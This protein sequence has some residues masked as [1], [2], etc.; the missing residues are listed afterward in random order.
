MNNLLDI[1]PKKVLVS[2]LILGG[3]AFIILQN[4]PK[5]LCDIQK[6]VFTSNQLGFLF[7]DP[8]DKIKTKTTFK[9]NL[10]DC[11]KNNNPG[12]CYSLF[13]NIPRVIQS[14][15]SVESSCYSQIAE[16]K[17]VKQSFFKTYSLF[18]EI[19][20]GSGPSDEFSNPLSW[21]S[22]N[23]VSTFCRLKRHIIL[24]YGVKALEQF[25]HQTFQRIA[26]DKSSQEHRRFSILSENCLSYP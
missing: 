25:E 7:K 10:E 20:W 17:E 8:T 5:T 13:Y 2:L 9:E 22:S 16:I 11:I 18:L 14:F 12:G 23:D 19:S 24:L 3:I 4:P 1:L 6:E 26:P 21:L 15:R